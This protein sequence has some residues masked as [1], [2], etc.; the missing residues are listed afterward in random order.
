MARQ[1]SMETLNARIEKAEQNVIRA[2]KAYSL[3]P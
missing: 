3:M 2:K 1:I